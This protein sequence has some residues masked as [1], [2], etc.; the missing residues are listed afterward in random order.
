MVYAFMW[1]HHA[2]N[3]ILAF[4]MPVFTKPTNAEHHYV[5]LPYT[6]GHPNRTI[7]VETWHKVHL[8]L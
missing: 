3:N 2:N 5:Q 6:E 4:L 1:F 8:G 7:N